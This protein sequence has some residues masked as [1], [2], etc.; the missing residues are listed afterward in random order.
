MRVEKGLEQVESNFDGG[1]RKKFACSHCG[2]VW[3]EVVGF[4]AGGIDG[5]DEVYFQAGT[6]SEICQNCQFRL[7]T[8]PACGSK[9]AYEINF[10]LNGAPD[11]PLSFERIRIVRKS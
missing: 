7:R 11:S 5:Q 4:F 6:E 2:K 1:L 9:D 8:C 10:P 3:V